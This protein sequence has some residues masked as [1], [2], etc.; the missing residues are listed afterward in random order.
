MA[1]AVRGAVEEGRLRTMVGGRR[2]RDCAQAAAQEGLQLRWGGGWGK[3]HG[4]GKEVVGAWEGKCTVNQ[5]PPVA[6]CCGRVLASLFAMGRS[7]ASGGSRGFKRSG[8]QFEAGSSSGD[9]WCQLGTIMVV[10]CDGSGLDLSV[11]VT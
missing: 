9:W 3:A 8:G 4:S 5:A 1:G 6:F 10:D 11:S 2:K 7:S